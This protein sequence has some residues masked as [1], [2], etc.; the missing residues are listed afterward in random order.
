LGRC[1]NGAGNCFYWLGTATVSRLPQGTTLFPQTTTQFDIVD[2]ANTGVIR[3][4]L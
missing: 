2:C 3:E 1:L 4:F